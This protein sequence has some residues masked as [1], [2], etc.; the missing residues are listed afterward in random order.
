VLFAFNQHHLLLARMAL[1]ESLQLCL[2]L[3][4]IALA[5]PR[6]WGGVLVGG[7]LAGFSIL[8]KV[9]SALIPLLVA[10]YLA[11]PERPRDRWIDPTRVAKAIA[12]GLVSAVVAA[13]VFGGLYLAHP[14]P[15]VHIFRKALDG[16]LFESKSRAVIRVGRFGLDHVLA[17][18]SLIGLLRESPFL[19]V[20]AALGFVGS[21]AVGRRPAPLAT[22][23]VVSGLAL[24]LVQ[25]YQP[26]RYFHLLAPAFCYFAALGIELLG[27]A[28]RV[29]TRRLQRGAL[30]L[31]A[32]FGLIYFGFNVLANPAIIL[33]ETARWARENTHPEDRSV[34]AFQFCTDLP[35]RAY[36]FAPMFRDP[37]HL[38]ENLRSHEIDY[39][40]DTKGVPASLR[41]AVRTH[42]VP[43]HRWSFGAVYRVPDRAVQV[44]TETNR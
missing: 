33:R 8:T 29:A 15:F 10:L 21:R 4:A 6:R 19:M 25:T 13:V 30:A 12:F 14:E 34:C 17:G 11:W 9:S 18:R 43:V 27:S 39:F 40:F 31:C 35:H 36:G 2:A 16:G 28:D 24:L 20:F 42:L 1:A 41:E 26:L 5:L 23:W 22:A 3:A 7:I 32:S 44:D 37:E 38:L